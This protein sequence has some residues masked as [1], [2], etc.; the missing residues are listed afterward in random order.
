MKKNINILYLLLA[1]LTITTSCN[2][3]IEDA[4]KFNSS[5]DE[6][7]T[8]KMWLLKDY[9]LFITKGIYNNAYEK[10]YG[11]IDYEAARN[12]MLNYGFNDPTIDLSPCFGLTYT[13]TIEN[14]LDK[15]L[16]EQLTSNQYALITELISKEKITDKDLKATREKALTL[17]KPEQEL[18][19]YILDASQAIIDG[20]MQGI[21]EVTTATRANEGSKFACNLA[22][23]AVGAVTGFLAGCLSGPAAGI[24]API[25]STTVGAYISTK[26][27]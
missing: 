6:L 25:V 26:A 10:Q 16:K 20:V 12:V 18:V 9:S 13:R 23:G 24:V 2:S 1:L 4:N 17:E 8:D 27:C 21:S 14:N 5:S 19:I 3:D 22:S 7:V 11:N 15:D